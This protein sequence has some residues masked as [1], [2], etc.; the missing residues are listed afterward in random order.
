MHTRPIALTVILLAVSVSAH[1]ESTFGMHGMA[2]GYGWVTGSAI[3]EGADI[4]S[5]ASGP[6]VSYENF[7]GFARVPMGV[8]FSVS[9]GLLPAGVVGIDGRKAFDYSDAD[10]SFFLNSILSLGLALSGQ[11][12]VSLRVL[13]GVGYTLQLARWQYTVVYPVWSG[14]EMFIGSYEGGTVG[15]TSI[16]TGV[17]DLMVAAHLGHNWEFFVGGVTSYPIRSFMSINST[18]LEEAVTGSGSGGRLG[19]RAYLGF[20]YRLYQRQQR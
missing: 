7:V 6:S 14:T 9:V 10:I 17:L 2:L 4:E 3:V 12:P 5:V 1:G 20:G 18:E 8:K 16:I 13:P 15:L 19:F 11:G